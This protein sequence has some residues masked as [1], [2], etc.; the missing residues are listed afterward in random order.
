MDSAWVV[1]VPGQ[2]CIK[3][4]HVSAVTVFSFIIQWSSRSSRSCRIVFFFIL[5][6]W[7]TCSIRIKRAFRCSRDLVGWSV[8][9]TV[10]HLGCS[11][12]DGACLSWDWQVARLFPRIVFLGRGCKSPNKLRFGCGS[13]VCVWFENFHWLPGSWIFLLTLLVCSIGYLL[14]LSRRSLIH[15]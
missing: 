15:T 12:R 13:L 2:I 7:F 11:P 9:Q 8:Y 4:D 5:L 10:H 1:I 6:C 3:K 14:G